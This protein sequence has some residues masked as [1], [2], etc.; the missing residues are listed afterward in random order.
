MLSVQMVTKVWLQE[1]E[2]KKIFL[3]LYCAFA[4]FSLTGCGYKSPYNYYPEETIVQY[5]A[6]NE[7]QVVLAGD[8][9]LHY[10]VEKLSEVVE[11]QETLSVLGSMI[12]RG[13]YEKTGEDSSNIY[14]RSVSTK[15]DRVE[16]DAYK[17]RG[18][19]VFKRSQKLTIMLPGD[20]ML[21]SWDEGWRVQK[22]RLKDRSD[23]FNMR[24]LTYVGSRGPLLSFRYKEGKTSQRITHNMTN[25]A[26]FSYRGAEIE[27][28][29]FDEHT[30][31]CKVLREFDMVR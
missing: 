8:N 28:L 12:P 9:I 21:W 15:G 16:N 1:D 31:T 19:V 29:S 7:V 20:Y 27:I 4:V 3:F 25:S 14:F 11:V 10:E 23:D 22:S 6:I 5:G 2:M 18:L 13:L 30:L 26:I 17:P 24:S